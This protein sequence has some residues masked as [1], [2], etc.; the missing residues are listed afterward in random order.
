[1]PVLPEK[2]LLGEETSPYLLQHKDNPV[3]WRP[4][5][6]A[7][8]DEARELNR[9]ILLSVGYAACHWCH[10]MA[11]E[12]FENDQV[13]DVMNRLFVNIKVDREER[14]EIDQ[15]YMAALS[16]TGE[17]GGW[18]LTMFLSPDGK[19][20]W[21]G[22]YFPPQQRYGRPGFI[23]V[24][25][26][27][28]TAWLEKNRDL[29]GS[30]ERLHD[31]VKA[32]LSPPS[33][34][35]FDPQSALTDLAE[36]IHGMIDQDMGGLRGAPKFP[37]MPFIQIL[38]LSWLQ[39]G[40]QSHR[41]SVITSLK[42]MLSG[43]IYDHVGGG[44]ARY[45][46]DANWLVPHFEKMLYDNAQ[47][48][49]L[50]SWVFG[51]TEDQLFRIRIEEVTNFLLRDMRVNGGAFASSLDADSEGE[52]GKAYLWSRLQIEA[53]LGS[54]TEAFLSTFELTKPDDWHGDPVLHRLGH[55][56]FQGTDTENALRNDLNAL[57]STRARRIQPGRDDK[58]LVDWNGLAI[59][60]IA[61]CARQFQRQ[62]WLD[63]AKAAFH[64]VCE[65]MESRR[66]PHSIR[67]GKRLFPAL[68]SDY[69]AMISA[70]T[71]LYQATR[72]RGFLDQASEW[73]E[74]L[75]SWNADEENAGF[76]LTSS[77]A[78][79]IPLRIRGDVD[80][81]MPSATALI[82]EAMCG[83][84]ALSGDDKM[85]EYLSIITERALGRTRS[86]A[87]GQ[88]GIIFSAVL[89]ASPM[90]LAMVE[91]EEEDL[92][93]PVANRIL[94][95]RRWD[96]AFQVGEPPIHLPGGVSVPTEA[97]AAYLCMGQTCL[98]A[99]K[100]PAVLQRVLKEHGV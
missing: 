60:A 55:P 66:L 7:A 81:A 2:N 5:S 42:R 46:T 14:P 77:D 15:I 58:V 61:N 10:V 98:P 85:E 71:A 100:E 35:G 75:K 31:H 79:D 72:E 29:S 97:P 41:D 73:F 22:T 92:F 62:D 28:H 59:A 96:E 54:R 38:W 53:V 74:T 94:D 51:E 26:A 91:A 39:T 65:S 4:W 95:P 83:L 11:H 6:K 49:R 16:A 69:A 12:S 3:H 25:N 76:Y 78:S 50:L 84:A 63:A 56:E 30:A 27:V 68:S 40:N 1:M 19:P 23:E 87:Y 32:R 48:L 17:Q 90:K 8:L 64:F 24:L 89:A 13:A 18:P 99:I 47:L 70:A 33:A 34:E 20:F 21:G 57:L 93:V 44:L 86:Q 80:E 82:I 67:L 37:N 43:G 9:P 52:E 88:A 36:R 45:S